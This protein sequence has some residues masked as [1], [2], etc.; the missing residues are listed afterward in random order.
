MTNVFSTML[1]SGGGNNLPSS[2]AQAL[3]N[4]HEE[5]STRNEQAQQSY[6]HYAYSLFA[7]KITPFV[8]N[9]ESCSS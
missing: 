1:F 4:E 6:D 9:S 7:F 5:Q 8:I 2:R 3:Q